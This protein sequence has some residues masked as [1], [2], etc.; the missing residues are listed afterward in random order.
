MFSGIKCAVCGLPLEAPE[1]QKDTDYL[2]N[3]GS[4]YWMNPKISEYTDIVVNFCGP[5]HSLEWYLKAKAAKESGE[6]VAHDND[7]EQ[8][9][10]TP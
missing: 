3:V 10:P 5:P 1:Y 9:Q 8:S 2:G 7:P 6:V 4:L